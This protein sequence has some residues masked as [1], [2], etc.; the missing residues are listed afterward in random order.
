MY[1]SSLLSCKASVTGLSKERG[2]LECPEVDVHLPP[3]SAGSGPSSHRLG[4]PTTGKTADRP[5]PPSPSL[6]PSGG[7][8]GLKTDMTLTSGGGR[9][10][11]WTK[12]SHLENEIGKDSFRITEG[13]RTEDWNI[14]R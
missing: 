13:F 6:S 4:S 5:A 1:S 8:E 10:A 11:R 14:I 3:A 2:V 9:G 12:M 7:P